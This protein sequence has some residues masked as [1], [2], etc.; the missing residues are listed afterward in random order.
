MVPAPKSKKADYA[1]LPPLVPK[2]ANRDATLE[3]LVRKWAKPVEDQ[4]EQFVLKDLALID[5]NDNTPI[6]LGEI[7]KLV[8]NQIQ[9]LKKQELAPYNSLSLSNCRIDRCNASNQ[10]IHF[11]IDISG[12]LFKNASF[13]EAM[14]GEEAS[15]EGAKFG[16]NTSFER[17]KFA[18]DA[19]FER[20]EFSGDAWFWETEFRGDAWFQ[21]TKF[22][23]DAW[24]ERAQFGGDAWFERTQFDGDAWFERAQFDADAWFE[25]TQF[26]ADTWFDG[27]TNKNSVHFISARFSDSQVFSDHSFHAARF[28][29]DSQNSAIFGRL[30]PK[31]RLQGH[32]HRFYTKGNAKHNWSLAR[33]FGELTILTR[34]STSGLFFVPILAAVWPGLRAMVQYYAKMYGY[35]DFLSPNMP[36]AWGM[37]FFAA[38]FAMLGRVVYQSACPEEVRERSRVDVIN[39]EMDTFRANRAEEGD[40]RLD[41]AISAIEEAGKNEYLRWFRHQNLVSHRGRTVWIPSK[42]EDFAY[43]R[44]KVPQEWTDEYDQKCKENPDV[45]Y[46]PPQ[47]AEAVMSRTSREDITIQA[48]AGAW[49]DIISRQNRVQ[50]RIA[51]WCYTL[52][53]ILVGVVIWEQAISIL[54]EMGWQ[55]LTD[56][57]ARQLTLW[58]LAII[59]GLLVFW[60]PLWSIAKEHYQK[61]VTK[62]KD[63]AIL[64]D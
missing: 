54:Q 27:V 1:N 57:R 31:K 8:N 10:A 6:D 22:G 53:V 44:S 30:L 63:K 45:E 28:R 64:A 46:E 48:G 61:L 13:D 43:D 47:L 21:G 40:R 18:G 50:A 17:A 5:E 11:D 14:F 41:E 36:D 62:R 20:A 29:T 12:C 7:L 2:G 23:G 15:F 37:L 49:Y 4:Q 39:Q 16:G 59:A 35:E 60:P 26:D 56:D 9:V 25:R 51:L 52:G 55:E 19:S 34:A 42:I 38:L 32:W 24:F 3:E 58:L 33:G